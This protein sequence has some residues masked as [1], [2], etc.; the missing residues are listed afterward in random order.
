MV[1]VDD[2]DLVL[3]ALAAAMAIEPD[4]E[5]VGTAMTIEE[6]LQ[7]TARS[8]P[9]VVVIDYWLPDGDGATGARRL[10]EADPGVRVVMLTGRGDDDAREQ[11]FAAGCSGFVAKGAKFD[12]LAHAVRAAA[13]AD[14]PPASST[15]ASP[16]S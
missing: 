1:L 14:P 11:A 12:Q 6:A 10:R 4:L 9:D 8:S 15:P 5:V 7:A 16:S 2:H 3:R 13:A